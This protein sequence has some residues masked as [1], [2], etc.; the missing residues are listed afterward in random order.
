MDLD[1]ELSVVNEDFWPSL[2]QPLHGFA[3]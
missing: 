2:N 1:R 3:L